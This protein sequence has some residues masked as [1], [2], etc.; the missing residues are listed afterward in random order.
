MNARPKRATPPFMVRRVVIFCVLMVLAGNG[1][2]FHL[3]PA[4]RGK[5]WTFAIQ[6]LMFVLM[7][8]ITFWFIAGFRRVTRSAKEMGGKICWRCGYNLKGLADEGTC[9]EC[10]DR[11]ALAELR[12]RWMPEAPD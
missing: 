5:P 3:L 7:A 6:G 10:G 4:F 8:G 12:R 11:Y 9:P 1:G 2:F